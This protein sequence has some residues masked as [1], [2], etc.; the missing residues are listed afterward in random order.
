MKRIDVHADGPASVD[1]AWQAYVHVDRWRDWSPHMPPVEADAVVIRPGAEG[2]WRLGPVT[3]GRFV[4][5]D[6]DAVART[7]NWRVSVLGLTTTGEHRVEVRRSG[8]RC[9]MAMDLPPLV[10][11]A[12]RPLAWW[13]LHRLARSS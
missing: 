5:T 9:H 13:A 6:V 8:C 3:V 1:A 12:Y 11:Q 10:G 4:I 2:R 7:W